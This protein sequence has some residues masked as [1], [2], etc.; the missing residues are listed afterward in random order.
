MAENA[1]IKEANERRTSI[2]K[3]RNTMQHESVD[4]VKL[5][6]DTMQLNA[7]LKNQLHAAKVA[8]EQT[9]LRNKEAIDKVKE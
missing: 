7:K 1:I 8:I 6:Q 9:D 5:L 4:T 2:E 3:E